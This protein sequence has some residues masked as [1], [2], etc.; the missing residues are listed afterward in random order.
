L[1]TFNGGNDPRE[2]DGSV[3]VQLGFDDGDNGSWWRSGFRKQSYG[4]LMTSSSSMT[5]SIASG[6]GELSSC[7]DYLCVLGFN[8]VGKNST[9]SGRYI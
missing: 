8:V 2:A 1:L 6:G 9:S 4:F 7:I 3:T 5:A